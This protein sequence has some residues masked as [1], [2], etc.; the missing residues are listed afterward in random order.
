MK[1]YNEGLATGLIA[2]T[3]IALI[4]IGLVIKGFTDSETGKRMEK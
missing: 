3:I 4:S 1:S 2:G